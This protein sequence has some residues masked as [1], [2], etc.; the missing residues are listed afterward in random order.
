MNPSGPQFWCDDATFQPTFT[1]LGMCT[2]MLQLIIL[3]TLL[4]LIGLSRLRQ[5]Q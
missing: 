3:L 1:P 2:S 5:G 4:D